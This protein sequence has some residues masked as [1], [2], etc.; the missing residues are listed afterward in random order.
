[1]Q[2]FGYGLQ[3]HNHQEEADTFIVLHCFHIAKIDPFREVVIVYADT[4]FLLILLY[5][6]QSLCTQAILSMG[7]G[8][9]KQHINIRK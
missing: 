3:G 6:R 8:D 9:C 5:H 7:T 4:D 2:D 1:M